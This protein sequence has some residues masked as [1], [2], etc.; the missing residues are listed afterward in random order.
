M[1]PKDFTRDRK[2]NATDIILYNMNNHGK[3][4]KMK[5]YNFIQ[6]V[7][8]EKISSLGFLKQRLK[9]DPYIFKLIN[10]DLLFDLYNFFQDIEK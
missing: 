7:E 5:L 4:I 6:K 10:S 9:L 2:I 3:T 1:K 8:K